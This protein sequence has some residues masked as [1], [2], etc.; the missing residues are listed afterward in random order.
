M[1]QSILLQTLQDPIRADLSS[2]L[3]EV[4]DGCI[5]NYF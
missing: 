1:R 5:A 3:L 4:D 2:K